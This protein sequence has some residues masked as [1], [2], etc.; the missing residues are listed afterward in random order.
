ME[1]GWIIS[2]LV[3]ASGTAGKVALDINTATKQ[4]QQSGLG[5]FLSS[6]VLLLWAGRSLTRVLAA[7]A[8]GGWVLSA[9][10]AKP[11][12]RMAGTLTGLIF[13]LLVAAGV[14]TCP[15]ARR[16]GVEYRFVLRVGRGHRNCLVRRHVVAAERN[17]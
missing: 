3:R 13:T 8:A 16:P 9:R 7:S 5:L 11:T 10:E 14:L 12:L 4:S 17:P 1:G 15:Q 6:L 2:S